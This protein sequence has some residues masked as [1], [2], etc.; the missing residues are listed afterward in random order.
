MNEYL[1]KFVNETEAN[2]AL[3]E[4]LREYATKNKVPI[5]K[6]DSLVA[7]N[8]LLSLKNAINSFMPPPYI[9]FLFL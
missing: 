3:F 9:L 2:H 1:E 7:I 4:R 6:R 5:I 8:C